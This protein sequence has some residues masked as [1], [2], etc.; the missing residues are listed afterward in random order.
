MSY[1]YFSPFYNF[2]SYPYGQYMPN[3][4]QLAYTPIYIQESLVVQSF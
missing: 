2:S 3:Q 4:C 1:F